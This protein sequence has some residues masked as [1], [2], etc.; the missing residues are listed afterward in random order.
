MTTEKIRIKDLEGAVTEAH[1][2]G[3]PVFLVI[4]GEALDIEW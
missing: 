2:G 3:Y 1:K 4:N